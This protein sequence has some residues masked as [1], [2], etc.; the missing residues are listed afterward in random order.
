MVRTLRI[1]PIDF[2]QNLL[3][4]VAK[5]P[6]ARVLDQARIAG[7]VEQTVSTL[8]EATKL[9]LETVESA[10]QQLTRLGL[11]Q[12]TRKV[13][14]MQAYTFNLDQRIRARVGVTGQLQ[15]AEQTQR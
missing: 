15:D 4:A 7:N 5:N 11:A 10:L 6:I 12:P 3:F 8:S 2:S 13:G 14:N 9:D 1:T